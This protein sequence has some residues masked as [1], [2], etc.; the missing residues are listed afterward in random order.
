MVSLVLDRGAS[1]ALLGLKGVRDLEARIGAIRTRFVKLGAEDFAAALE[2]V[3]VGAREGGPAHADVLL[4]SALWLIGEGAEVLGALRTA[5][6]RSGHVL[7]AAMLGADAAHAAG[8]LSAHK[9]MSPHGRLPD[10]GLLS[11]VGVRLE[12]HYVEPELLARD[13][14]P[15]D[16]GPP[17]RQPFASGR[18]LARWTV[19]FRPEHAFVRRQVERLVQHPDPGAIARLLRHRATK[20]GDVVRV[21]ARRPMTPELARAITDH[22][23]WMSHLPVRVALASN[24]FTPT[25]TALLLVPTCRPRLRVLASANAHPRVRALAQLLA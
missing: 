25:R 9:T 14:D 18:G 15:W 16:D 5:S 12:A 19:T 7:L 21:A 2:H 6:E 8:D 3:V 13:G 23:L 11:T 17:A 1:K 22:H 24:P 10:V 20:L 4:A